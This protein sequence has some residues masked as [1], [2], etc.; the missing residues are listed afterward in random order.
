MTG[1]VK[2]NGPCHLNEV[3]PSPDTQHWARWAASEP[4][5]AWPDGKSVAVTLT[6]DV[7]AETAWYGLGDEYFARLTSLSEGRYSVVRAVPRILQ[8]LRRLDLRTTFFVP[9]WTAENY[10]HVVEAILADGHEIGHHGYVHSRTDRVSADVQREEIERGFSALESIG[11]PRPRG[12]RNPSWEMTTETAAMV[13]EYGFLYDSSFL[14]DDRPY[15][16]KVGDVELLELPSHWSLDDWPYFGYTGDFGGNTS[17]AATWRQNQWDEYQIARDEGRNVN[18]VCH[19]EVIGR[20]YRFTQLAKLLEDILADGRAWFP[21]ME[22]LALH[23]APKLLPA[24]SR[25]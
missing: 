20:G 1:V 4:E 6:F 11:V 14:T 3:P 15:I 24:R 13:S 10:P 9:G 25:S 21:T 22:E 8:L 23:V 2:K 17:T 7:D 5:W 16:E 19:P 18:F 12:Y